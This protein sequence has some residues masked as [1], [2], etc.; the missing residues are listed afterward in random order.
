LKQVEL[1]QVLCQKDEA[2][3]AIEAQGLELEHKIE[4]TETLRA[5]IR[6]LQ[7]LLRACAACACACAARFSLV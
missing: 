4:Q 6:R 2:L 3:A 1:S 5:V 7:G